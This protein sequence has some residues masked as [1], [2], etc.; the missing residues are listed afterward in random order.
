MLHDLKNARKYHLD[1]IGWDEA[2]VGA[3]ALDDWTL[4]LTLENPNSLFS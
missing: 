2:Q 4:Q 3:V 1:G